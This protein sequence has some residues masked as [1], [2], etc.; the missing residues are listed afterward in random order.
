MEQAEDGGHVPTSDDSSCS[1]HY[2]M[3]HH[4]HHH[5]HRESADGRHRRTRE[6]PRRKTAGYVSVRRRSNE[7]SQCWRNV[8]RRKGKNLRDAYSIIFKAAIKRHVDRFFSTE[9]EKYTIGK[10]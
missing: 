2:H 3:H 10:F 8:S 9:Y 5:M 6:S 1:H 4:H 7:V